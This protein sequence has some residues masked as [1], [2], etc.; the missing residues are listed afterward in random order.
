[1]SGA[2]EVNHNVVCGMI[3]VLVLPHKIAD[4]IGTSP[5]TLPAG[6]TIILGII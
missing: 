5:D 6:S 4:G 1:M 3:N 2:K